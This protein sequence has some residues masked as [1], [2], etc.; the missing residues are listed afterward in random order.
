MKVGDKLNIQKINIKGLG[1]VEFDY[2]TVTKDYDIFLTGQDAYTYIE[3]NASHED[4]ALGSTYGFPV[5]GAALAEADYE[6]FLVVMLD[7]PEE[8]QDE[9]EDM[10]CFEVDDPGLT[11]AL[12]II[13]NGV[14]D[15]IVMSLAQQWATQRLYGC[16]K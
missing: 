2:A 8:F 11:L 9:F 6:W 3:K 12:S 16:T 10:T 5:V 14:K 15:E 1:E 4:H 7:I 13:S